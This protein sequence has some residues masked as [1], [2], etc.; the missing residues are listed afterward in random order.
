MNNNPHD[1]EMD[2]PQPKPKSLIKTSI[3]LAL[4]MLLGLQTLAMIGAYRLHKESQAAIE[5]WKSAS[6]KAIESVNAM[7]KVARES[8]QIA[9]ESRDVANRAIEQ[10]DQVQAKFNQYVRS[11]PKITIGSQP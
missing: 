8:Q 11:N 7:E 4:S 1:E 10:R 9:A 6:T 2:Q 5:G 3:I